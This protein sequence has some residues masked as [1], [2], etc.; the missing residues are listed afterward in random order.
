MTT[1]G[2]AGT[3]AAGTSSTPLQTLAMTILIPKAKTT[4][5]NKRSPEYIDANSQSITMT[6]L[7]IDGTTV[8]NATAQGPYNLTPASNP[9]CVAGAAG[10]TCTLSV[11]APVGTDIFLATTYSAVNAGGTPLGSGAVKFT[12]TQNTRN[13]ASLSLTGPVSSV[14][15][16]SGTATLYN[17]NPVQSSNS[18]SSAAHRADWASANARA[19]A[20]LS[21]A[22]AQRSI[23][24]MRSPQTIATSPPTSA[25]AVALTSRLFVIALDAAGNQII[26]PTTFDIPI[27]LKLNLN[28]APAGSLTLGVTYAGLPSEPTT[29]ASTT[30]DGGTVTID[31][32]S[33]VVSLTVSSSATTIT[34]YAPSVVAQ[35]TPQGGA[36]QTTT[37]L[38]YQLILP[39]PA[40]FFSGTLTPNDPW[41]T[42]QT[43]SVSFTIT[44]S[45]TLGTTQPT[46]VSIYT[47]YATILDATGSSAGWT[48]SPSGTSMNCNNPNPLAAGA[49]TTIVMH[50]QAANTSQDHVQI[51]VDNDD[52]VNGSS[53]L[54]LSSYVAIT[55]TPQPTLAASAVP[56]ATPMYVDVPQPIVVNVQNAGNAATSGTIT[57]LHSIAS[58]AAFTYSGASGTGWACS[59]T[60]TTVS[61]STSAVAAPGATF[62]PLTV[63]LIPGSAYLDTFFNDT[64][65]V[66]G[67]GAGGSPLAYIQSI[68][69][70]P[71]FF[72][73]APG[74]LV[75]VQNGIG[76]TAGSGGDTSD[77]TLGLGFYPTPAPL[78]GS[79][80]LTEKATVSG[81][82]T[83]VTDTCVSGSI[84]DGTFDGSF[85]LSAPVAGGAITPSLK[86]LGQSSTPSPCY[87][88]I[89]DT[90]GHHASLNITMAGTTG[91][92]VQSK[93]RTTGATR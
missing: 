85:P 32:P 46:S 78:S 48:C 21:I 77:A 56:I 79:V 8:T 72:S 28:G 19:A 31:A 12:V 39:P 50:V 76:F 68:V 80:E 3:P 29:P 26:N 15:V 64:I 37:P 27:T 67:G 2:V 61:C 1:P 36:P 18:N 90:A 87:I 25:P 93:N 75:G 23:A 92:T 53:E 71:L 52:I 86:I 33:D 47:Y 59:P 35:F 89:G 58:P 55:T 16:V 24:A 45:G 66:S 65:Q 40:A 20:A 54:A 63:T 4:S 83:V 17:G 73:A 81:N 49:S 9:N 82:L 5:S 6:L 44:N 34:V 7:S 42:G 11:S 69:R 41:V 60:T 30:A 13:V 51:H 84:I 43:S 70:S 22:S 88:T 14:Q 10:T 91:I 62:P 74:F 38:S 57:V